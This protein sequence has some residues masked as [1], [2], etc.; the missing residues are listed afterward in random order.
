M[1][2]TTGADGRG[3]RVLSG[4]QL[5]IL[6]R[7]MDVRYALLPS[8]ARQR[9]GLEAETRA[10]HRRSRHPSPAPEETARTPRPNTLHTPGS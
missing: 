5:G 1:P 4:Q 3:P 2:A 8:A 6:T 7:A 9:P 10:A